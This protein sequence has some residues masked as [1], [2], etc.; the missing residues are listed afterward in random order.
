[1]FQR[2]LTAGL[3]CGVVF[4]FGACGRGPSSPPGGHETGSESGFFAKGRSS[5]IRRVE[6]YNWR[7]G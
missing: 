4:A 2:I 1:M 6:N 3:L 5:F 7:S